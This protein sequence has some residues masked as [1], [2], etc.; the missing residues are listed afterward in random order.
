MILAGLSLIVNIVFI[1]FAMHFQSSYLSYEI[2]YINDIIKTQFSQSFRFVFHKDGQPDY[3]NLR[4]VKLTWL[5]LLSNKMI[6]SRQVSK[7]VFGPIILLSI[8]GLP[9]TLRPPVEK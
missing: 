4:D 2:I 9:Y 6:I 8:V 1:S 7:L 5:L 3:L